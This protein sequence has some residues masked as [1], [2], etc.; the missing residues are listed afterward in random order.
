MTV[1]LHGSIDDN[2]YRWGQI[3]KEKF[4][5]DTKLT[6]PENQVHIITSVQCHGQQ[7]KDIDLVVFGSLKDYSTKVKSAVYGHDNDIKERDV[8]ISNFCV[9]IEVK[10]HDPEGLYFSGTHLIAKYANKS[11]HNVTLQS[12]KQPY[13]LKGYLKSEIWVSNL[14][15]LPNTSK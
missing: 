3:L 10:G 12:Q 7:P 9:V 1:K 14:I 5:K 2:E 4:E 13:S 11:E 8:K 15:F 6:S